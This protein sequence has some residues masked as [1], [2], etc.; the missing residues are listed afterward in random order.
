M[1]VTIDRLCGRMVLRIQ[2]LCLMMP[3]AYVSSKGTGPSLRVLLRSG[4][5]E[6]LVVVG[7]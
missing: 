5:L 7:Q 6:L 1:R 3:R 2:T 4:V